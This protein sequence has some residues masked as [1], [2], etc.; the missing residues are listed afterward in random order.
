MLLL[1]YYVI[2]T[3]RIYRTA[4]P[5]LGADPTSTSTSA[6]PPTFHIHLPPTTPPLG[7]EPP[8]HRRWGRNPHHTVVG[9]GTPQYRRW[10]RNPTIPSLGAEPPPHRRWGRNPHHTVVGGGTPQ[11]RRWGRNPTIPSLGGGTP[12]PTSTNTTPVPPHLP[13]HRGYSL[14]QY[15]HSISR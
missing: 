8:P 15:N 10:G 2:L 3:M 1:C 4:I 14:N 5:S 11:Y 12:R 13:S 9:G 7:A 6:R